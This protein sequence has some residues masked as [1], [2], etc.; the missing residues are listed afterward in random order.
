MSKGLER[1]CYCCINLNKGESNSLVPEY[2][3]ES[4]ML[5][6]FTLRET[7]ILKQTL[8]YRYHSFVLIQLNTMFYINK[9]DL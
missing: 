4:E 7:A 5:L 1:S 6:S 8:K 2:F 9:C 3:K